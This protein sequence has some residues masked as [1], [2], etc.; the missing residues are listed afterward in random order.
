MNKL[1]ISFAILIA[2]GRDDPAA[3]DAGPNETWQG[4]YAL[5]WTCAENTCD[6]DADPDVCAAN[7]CSPAPFS[8]S[9]IAMVDGRRMRF[10]H[11]DQGVAWIVDYETGCSGDESALACS[12]D[13]IPPIAVQPFELARDADDGFSGDLPWRIHAIGLTVT[14]HVEATYRCNLSSDGV[15]VGC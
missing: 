6:P 13:A 11:L 12:G 3:P 5:T 4:E 10:W 2:C 15:P 8:T 7:A 9:T 14:W 1:A